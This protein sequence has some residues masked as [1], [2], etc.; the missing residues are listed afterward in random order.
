MTARQAIDAGAQPPQYAELTAVQGRQFPA[1]L[2]TAWTDATTD[3]APTGGR[4]ALLVE[5]ARRWPWQ[6]W[7]GPGGSATPTP[8]LAVNDAFLAMVLQVPIGHVIDNA[9]DYT[10]VWWR[11]VL[12]RLPRGSVATVAGSL[13]FHAREP[14]GLTIE[15]GAEQHTRHG[16]EQGGAVRQV[17]ASAQVQR[18][19]LRTHLRQLAE[20]GMLGVLRRASGTDWGC[21]A[22][23]MPL[24]A[25]AAAVPDTAVPDTGM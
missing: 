17:I 1:W 23:T 7:I 16:N 9:D 8:L 10:D 20:D 11:C 18:S 25:L 24:P 12:R 21:Y 14:G 3:D 6:V 15:L 13:V 19:T 2:D 22:L 4:A 5:A